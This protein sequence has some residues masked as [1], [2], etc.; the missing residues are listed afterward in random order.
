MEP[1]RARIAAPLERLR[2]GLRQAR[3][4]EDQLRALFAFLTEIEAWEHEDARIQRLIDAGLRETAGEEAQVWN[5][6][7]GTLDQLLALMDG[8]KLPLSELREHLT[9]SLSAS[10]VK[11]LPI[12]GDAVAAQ[13]VDVVCTRAAKAVLILG[14]ADSAAGADDGLLTSSQRQEVARRTRAWLGPADADKSRQTSS[15]TFSISPTSS[16]VTGAPASPSTQQM[17]LH[18][19]RSQQNF[20]VSMSLEISTSPICNIG[21]IGIILLGVY[22]SEK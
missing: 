22:L 4:L 13:S 21:G 1:I 6:I 2:E 8:E 20:S 11:T 12:S 15:S 5:R 3:A 7:L 9:D 10:I 18:L 16:S 19:V 14:A 17:P